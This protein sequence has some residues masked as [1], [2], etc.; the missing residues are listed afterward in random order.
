MFHALGYAMI[1]SKTLWDAFE[2]IAHYKKVVSNTCTLEL[3]NKAQ[4]TA[5]LS[6]HV[7]RYE[8]SQRPVLDKSCVIV[9]LATILRFAKE[10]SLSEI[11]PTKLSVNW[12]GTN[13]QK[14]ILE[15]YFGCEVEFDS[16][17]IE[18]S[19][20]LKQVKEPLVSGNPI[21]S[22]VNDKLLDEY[23]QRL[24]KNDLIQ[25]VKNKIQ[26]MLPLGSPSQTE[27]ADN[28]GMSLRN[29]QR[30]LSDK[31]TCY[32]DLLEQTRKKLALDYISHEHL[33]Y[34]EI[35]YLVGFSNIGNFNRAF[36]R[37]TNLT[38]GQYR[39]NLN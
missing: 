6:M 23:L 24:D 4:D 7:L 35:G 5:N 22:M 18:L 34:S 14:Q 20:N 13:S 37:W 11:N 12:P 16:D 26:E 38:P 27:L 10:M 39:R 25:Q 17:V 8:D 36:K 28:I 9:F 15:R 21:L 33:S 3:S 19:F 30:K 29:L 31:G 2:R 32:R 1:S